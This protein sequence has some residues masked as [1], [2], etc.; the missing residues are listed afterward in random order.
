MRWSI[1]YDQPYQGENMKKKQL[2]TLLA[3]P[4]FFMACGD[5]S[6]SSAADNGK[7]NSC[8]LNYSITQDENF[9]S[10]RFCVDVS[11]SKD[12][13]RVMNALC[14]DSYNNGILVSAKNSRECPSNYQIT[15]VTK[16]DKGNEITYY[17]YD[18]DATQDDCKEIIDVLLLNDDYEILSKGEVT[19]IFD[20]EDQTEID[21][22]KLTDEEK[23]FE[24]AYEILNNNYLF[25]HTDSLVPEGLTWYKQLASRKDYKGNGK[26]NIS[27]KYRSLKIPSEIEDA[28]FMYESLNDPFTEYIPPQFK[29]FDEFLEDFED[30]ETTEGHGIEFDF[31]I[32]KDED[33][34]YYFVVNNVHVGSAAEKNGIQVGDS[35]IKLG[36]GEKENTYEVVVVKYEN[37]KRVEKEIILKPQKYIPPTVTYEIKDSIAIIHISEFSSENTP[38]KRGTYGEFLEAL[39]ATENT[40]ATIIDLIGNPG[41]DA[42]QCDSVS[43]AMVHK[44]DTMAYDIYAYKD[45]DTHKPSWITVPSIADEDGIASNRYI[46]FAANSESASC[47][48]YTLISVTNTRK[49]PIVG[50]T[51]YGKGVGVGIQRSYLNGTLLFTTDLIMDKNHET[52]HA[53]GI[54]PDV[55]EEDDDEILNVAMEIAKEGTLKRTHGYGKNITPTYSDF[56]ALYKKND[57]H[58]KLTRADLGM[59]RIVDNAEMLE[60]LRK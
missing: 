14:Q 13:D 58:H 34:P 8:I 24:N 10:S 39:K 20:S 1:G 55:E 16:D 12:A 38:N 45:K 32:T 2:A 60:N 22:S 4:L 9:I 11:D 47:S 48:E 27:N 44:N 36:P 41:G 19:Q 31:V 37:G 30:R 21:F 49:S 5:E 35:L 46:V 33:H 52:Y 50:N 7:N 6:S 29:S 42:L 56:G 3:A 54:E 57:K 28:V 59:Y 15:C 26:K 23:E 40:K 25:A 43:R 53:H 51:T 18:K 17:A